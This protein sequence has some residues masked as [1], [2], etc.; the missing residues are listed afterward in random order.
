MREGGDSHVLRFKPS[1]MPL[2]RSAAARSQQRLPRYHQAALPG[3]GVKLDPTRLVRVVNEAERLNEASRHIDQDPIRLV[4][5]VNQAGR[6]T[7]LGASNDNAARPNTRNGRGSEEAEPASLGCAACF[8]TRT[9][10]V[11]SGGLRSRSV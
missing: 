1:M 5:M 7:S 9:S 4:R 2:L 3:V 6:L 10:R 11:G 8:T